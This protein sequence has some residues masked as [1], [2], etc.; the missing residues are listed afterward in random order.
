MARTESRGLFSFF[1]LLSRYRL[2]RVNTF[3]V[4]E[5]NSACGLPRTATL[6]VADLQPFSVQRSMIVRVTPCFNP[7]VQSSIAKKAWWGNVS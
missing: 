2:R 7:V 6:K 3:W 4:G 5:P 1:F